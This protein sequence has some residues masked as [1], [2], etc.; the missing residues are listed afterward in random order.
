MREYVLVSDST[1]DLPIDVIKDLG[2]KILPFSYSINDEVFEYYL[3]ERDGEIS[4]FY[5]RLRAGDMPIT[6]QVNIQ[7]YTD[8]FEGFIK[9]GKDI[10]YLAFSS[11]L[12]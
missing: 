5:D 2:I 12:S 7:A 6:A 10:L 11:G 8:L 3:D 4:A 1:C 9:E